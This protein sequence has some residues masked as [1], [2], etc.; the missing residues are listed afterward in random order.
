MS[1]IILAK[2]SQKNTRP[3]V[4]V[5][6]FTITDIV[7][8]TVLVEGKRTGDMRLDISWKRLASATTT[9]ARYIVGQLDNVFIPKTLLKEQGV[10]WPEDTVITGMVSVRVPERYGTVPISLR[11][12][13]KAFDSTLENDTYIFA[14]GTYTVDLG[15]APTGVPELD[16]LTVNGALSCVCEHMD[17]LLELKWEHVTPPEAGDVLYYYIY[18]ADGSAM[19]LIGTSATKTY[20]LP[21]RYLPIVNNETLLLG[22]A[23]VGR[24]AVVHSTLKAMVTFNI[25]PDVITSVTPIVHTELEKVWTFDIELGKSYNSPIA[26]VMADILVTKDTE[27]LA[28]VSDVMLAYNSNTGHYELDFNGSATLKAEYT[29]TLIFYAVD[30]Q[31]RVSPLGVSIV[32]NP[33]EGGILYRAEGGELVRCHVYHGTEPTLCTR[34]LRKGVTHELR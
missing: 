18:L 11:V 8:E 26:Y 4:S 31:E 6:E 24:Y 17:A 12:L 25:A 34:T 16:T 5:S 15:A 20:T 21:V 29:I 23:S 1:N 3:S 9:E 22:V 14:A 27:S 7:R 30:E 19:K 10:A 32:F 2:V 28:Q 13:S 33:L